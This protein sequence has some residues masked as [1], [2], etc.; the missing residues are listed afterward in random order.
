MLWTPEQ[1]ALARA[2]RWELV[3]CV[4]NGS[5]QPRLRCF[6]IDGL[7]NQKAQIN[8]LA[9]ARLGQ[10]LHIAALSAISASSIDGQKK[11][12]KA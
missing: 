9:N 8:V 2:E 7:S 11:R 6:G 3:D 4:D 1:Q 5:T 10:K 12:K